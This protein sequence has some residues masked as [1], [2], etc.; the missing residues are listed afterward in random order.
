[1]S[2]SVVISNNVLKIL[3]GKRKTRRRNSLKKGFLHRISAKKSKKNRRK[4]D[5]R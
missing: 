2:Q 3:S 5:W 1:M 4:S